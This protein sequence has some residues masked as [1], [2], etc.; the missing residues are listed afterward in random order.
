MLG[1]LLHV[2]FE[3]ASLTTLSLPTV[4]TGPAA[5]RAVGFVGAGI[6]EEVLFRLGLLPL[7]FVALRTCTPRWFALAAAVGV[8]SLVFSAAHYVDPAEQEWW[9][10]DLPEAINRI[11]AAPTIGRQPRFTIAPMMPMR[12]RRSKRPRSMTVR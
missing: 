9:I 2:G 1:Q 5:A 6:Y 11:V 7:C 12:A 8:T 10:A 4:A 3:R